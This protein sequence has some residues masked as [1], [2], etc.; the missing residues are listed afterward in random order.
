MVKSKVIRLDP[1]GIKRV[2]D[3]GGPSALNTTLK[4]PQKSVKNKSGKDKLIGKPTTLT[5][6][7][8]RML[9]SPVSVQYDS[10]SSENSDSEIASILADN[11]APPIKEKHKQNHAELSLP[12]SGNQNVTVVTDVHCSQGAEKTALFARAS[13]ESPNLDKIAEDN[14]FTS[15][16]KK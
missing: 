8:K 9:R 12:A 6:E 7:P 16:T 15:I 3:V 1:Q 10:F 2:M 5:K 11:K 4:K 13:S 14:D